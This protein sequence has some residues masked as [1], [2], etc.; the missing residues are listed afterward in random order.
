ML[1]IQLLKNKLDFEK[2]FLYLVIAF[3]FILPLSH[4]L[5]SFFV[6]LLTLFWFLEGNFQKKFKIIKNN[7]LLLSISLFLVWGLISILWTS[8]SKDLV[9][10]IRLDLYFVSF[11][12]IA[13]SI[14]REDINKIITAF[15]SGMFISEMIAYGVFFKLWT[16]KHA[17]PVNP[18]PFMIHIDY[19]VFLAFSSIL[20]LNRIFSN[21]YSKKEKLILFFFFLTVTGNLFLS[22][23][24]TGQVALIAA[25]FVLPVIHYRL[26][27]KSFIVS[28][29]LFSTIF[30][31]AYS[32]SNSF[33]MR[34]HSTSSDITRIM[35]SNLN[36]SWGIRVAYWII[37]FDAFKERPFGSGLGS[38]IITIQKEIE[39][40]KYPFINSRTKKFMSKHHP[41]NQY[42]LVILQT[43][44]IG[45]L[46]FINII[47]QLLRYKMQ[48]K[49]LKELSILFTTIFFVSC[50]AE[51][52]LIKQFPLV[53]FILFVGLFAADGIKPLKNN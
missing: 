28:L 49:A 1:K 38:H 6:V 4:A 14:K 32:L 15:L 24:R 10:S 2:I 12:V 44:F 17:T 41:H 20:L 11:F 22:T 16:F 21:L 27:I 47:Y 19:S 23:G 40:H 51:P 43:G 29:L 48:T 18:S 25:L 35:H 13:T 52:L 45:L 26:T 53:L 37:T 36:G 7:K 30:Y 9:N 42:L 39:K 46:L 34:V 33:V 3:A 5:V 8:I 50:L 31:S